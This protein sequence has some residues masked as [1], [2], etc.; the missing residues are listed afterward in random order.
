MTPW[1]RIC[2][3]PLL[4]SP[5]LWKEND[6]YDRLLIQF[7]FVAAAIE[8]IHPKLFEWGGGVGG[9]KILCLQV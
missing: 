6:A 9:I 8:K 4:G 1:H 5:Q 2:L 7:S 3:S